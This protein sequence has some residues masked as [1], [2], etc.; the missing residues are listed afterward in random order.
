MQ[1][2]HS[3][4]HHSHH[5]AHHH[6]HHLPT[7]QQGMVFIIAI[8]LNSGFIGVEFYYGFTINSAALIADAGHNLSDV[9]SL[10]LAWIAALLSKTKPNQRFT[11][12]LRSTSIMAALINAILLFVACG[13]I[14][15]ESIQRFA[16]P[17]VQQGQIVTLVAMVGILINGISAW[18]F[19]KDSHHDLNI[20]AAYLHMLA[21][22]AVSV[23]VVI[24]GVVMIYTDWYWLD[25]AMSL[26]IVTV[27]LLS[28]TLL[29]FDSFQLALNAVPKNIN[30]AEV[31]EFLSQ[32]PGVTDVHCLHVWGLSTTERAL[33]AHLVIPE[34]H[35]GDHVIDHITS[36]IEDK[37]HI[38]HC[39]LQIEHGTTE[40][41]CPLHNPN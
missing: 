9:L 17:P 18:L 37:F 19:V 12:G 23:G 25:P 33:T 35:P 14:A 34:G 1:K 24:A 21:D 5:H 20:R 26:L 29:F 40:H 13:A 10:F 11:Y 16:A 6:Q 32:H 39:T 41:R 28:T 2:N 38:Q 31:E 3:S 4:E 22:T 30:L 8:L 27:I 7:S 15:W 36:A